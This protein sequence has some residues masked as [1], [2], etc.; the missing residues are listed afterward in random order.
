[1]TAGQPSPDGPGGGATIR[2]LAAS[3]YLP[4]LLFGLG[5]GAIIPVVPLAAR[6]LGAS[7]AVA[8]FVVGLRG[9]G[10]LG[11]DLPAGWLVERIGERRAMMAATVVLAVAL[12]GCVVADG[13]LLFGICTL[14]IGCAWSVWLL[15]RLAYV[16]EVV[17][18]ERRGRALAALGGS[19][20]IGTFIG[21]FCG[22]LA[23]RS[24]GLDGAF[25][26]H[27]A[28][29]V[30]GLAVLVWAT[31]HEPAAPAGDPAPARPRP[32]GIR[33]ALATGRDGAWT[34]AGA[35]VAVGL[36]R[37]SRQVL[38]WPSDRNRP[39]SWRPP[40][41]SGSATASAAGS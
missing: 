13:L 9:L 3:V 2:S 24:I 30:L 26:I 5:Q 7:V 36:L 12:T 14:V 10:T 18:V 8:G 25:W 6:G 35:T 27:I 32:V 34:A 16:T 1:M 38:C 15:A 28:A 37:T 21:P 40:C 4:S 33:R 20:R 29:S 11:F 39:S 19:N 22:A 41:S 31:D 23:V 17:P